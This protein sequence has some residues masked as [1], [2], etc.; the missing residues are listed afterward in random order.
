MPSRIAD[1]REEDLR[2]RF[3]HLQDEIERF[4]DLPISDKFDE[5]FESI[6]ER[7]TDIERRRSDVEANSDGGRLYR[8]YLSKLISTEE[9]IENLELVLTHLDLHSHHRQHSSERIQRT[10][11]ICDE[12]TDAF[13]ITA[14][15]LPVVR[16]NYA[17]LPLLDSEY[18]VIYIP[19]GRDI[20]PTTPLLAHEVAHAILDQRSSRS[21]KFNERFAELRR[22]MDSERTERD[23]HENW[24][25]WYDELFCDVAGF[26]AFGP[27]YVYAQLHHLFNNRPYQIRRDV[28]V[29]DDYLHPPDALRVDVVTDLADEYLPQQ[30]Q[31][32]LGPIREAY[33]THQQQYAEYK[34]SFYDT[35]ADEQLI[36]A[37]IEDAEGVCSELDQL[38]Q[39]LLDGTDPEDT[40]E[41]RYRIKANQYWLED[42]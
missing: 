31:D 19:R 33:A 16:E 37:I 35:W 32:L 15:C 39:H 30:L 2:A 20:V 34:P 29:D 36:D 23:F 25:Y 7:F 12:L 40:D 1:H 10:E 5:Y 8:R 22:R 13:E 27:S 28:R 21:E 17:L 9:D 4:S 26:F 11:A 42:T 41:F 18:Y 38:C 14:T 24:D 3:E 6:Q